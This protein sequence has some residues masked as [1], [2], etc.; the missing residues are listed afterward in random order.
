MS[1]RKQDTI[2]V[3]K[4]KDRGKTGKVVSVNVKAH[5]AVVEGLNQYKKQVKPSKKYPQ[6]GIIDISLPIQTANLMVI[7]PTCKKAA[8]SKQKNEGREKRRVCAKCSEVL[9]A[10]K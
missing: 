9:D 2:L 8:R 1:I 4:G 3:I 10:T 7:C 6:G 5:K